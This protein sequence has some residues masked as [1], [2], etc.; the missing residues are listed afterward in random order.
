MN[1]QASE[2][3]LLVKHNSEEWHHMWNRLAEHA[4]NRSLTAPARLTTAAKTG[5][6]L[7]HWSHHPAELKDVISI[8]SDTVVT[9]WQGM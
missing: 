2:I 4:F 1:T 7:K 6:T 5:S 9:L 8:T 3:S